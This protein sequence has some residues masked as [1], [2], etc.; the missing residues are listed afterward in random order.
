MRGNSL[1]GKR[2]IPWTPGGDEPP[3]RPEKVND[4]TSVMYV[5]GKSDDRVLPEKLPNNGG[6]LPPAEGVEERR[7]TE[8]NTPK[9]ARPGHRAGPARRWLDSVC[10]KWH[11]EIDVHGSPPY[12]TTSDPSFF[13]RALMPNTLSKG[14]MR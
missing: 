14:R 1:R 8:A 5:R 7:P 3:G 13:E 4:R 2:E 12:C 11:V 6:T 9:A 10:M